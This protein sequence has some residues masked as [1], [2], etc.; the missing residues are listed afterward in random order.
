MARWRVRAAVPGGLLGAVALWKLGAI[1]HTA[2]DHI[3]EVVSVAGEGAVHAAGVVVDIAKETVVDARDAAGRLVDSAQATVT[4]LDTELEQAQRDAAEEAKQK[5][6]DP[7]GWTIW[8]THRTPGAV[9]PIRRILRATD[10]GRTHS[11]ELR[12]S[13]EIKLCYQAGS[14]VV[15]RGDIVL[16]EAPMPEPPEEVYFS[17][18]VLIDGVTLCRT[19]SLRPGYHFQT[20]PVTAHTP[21]NLAW[22]LDPDLSTHFASLPDGG[23]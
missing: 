7:N 5:N 12:H 6:N 4:R 2:S 22:N 19:G 23:M 9:S 3:T 14:C 18:R 15:T 13:S 8:S 20:D 1:L 17:G 10:S 11:T 21:A 16:L